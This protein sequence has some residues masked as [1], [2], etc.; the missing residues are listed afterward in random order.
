MTKDLQDLKY[1]ETKVWKIYFLNPRLEESR[2]ELIEEL[3]EMTLPKWLF[4]FLKN[5]AYKKWNTK[6]K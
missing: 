2:E 6:N 1:K 3:K 5:Y 4:D